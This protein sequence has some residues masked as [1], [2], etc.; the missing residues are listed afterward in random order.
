MWI[1]QKLDFYRFWEVMTFTAHFSHKANVYSTE[2]WI[3]FNL[4]SSHQI[5]CIDYN[6]NNKL[7]GLKFQL[8]KGHENEGNLDRFNKCLVNFWWNICG[9]KFISQRLKQCLGSPV[10]SYQRAFVSISV[11]P[12]HT[13]T[14]S[15]CVQNVEAPL[16]GLSR[17]RKTAERKTVSLRS[18]ID[19]V[20]Y[21][22]R[23]EI[24]YND[25]TKP[26][27]AAHSCHGLCCAFSCGWS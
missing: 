1:G 11:A 22:R 27:A 14:S 25:K 24:R 7:S 12:I 2:N 9:F 20:G 15:N 17:N 18:D 19:L 21:S 6:K 8:K 16:P 3:F 10:Y 13:L 4:I 26:S 23:S 5:S